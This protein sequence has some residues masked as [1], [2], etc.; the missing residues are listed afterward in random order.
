MN[1]ELNYRATVGSQ[2]IDLPLIQVAEGISIALLISVDHGIRFAEV[3]GRELASALGSF[4]I[5]IVASVATMGIP[6]AIEVTR[7][8][9]LDD[10]VIL[11][12]TPKIHLA[13]AVSEPVRSITTSSDQHLLFDRA[14]M[15][16]ISGSG[17]RLS[18][19]S[20]P[21][22]DRAG[23]RSTSSAASAVSRSCSGRS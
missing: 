9:G 1:G 20:S 13:D 11:H 8:L 15:G 19:M 3:A 23:R 10:Y 6:L 12:K 17:W 22:E 5:E 18:T 16:A 14:R 21:L 4:D 2:Q 7:A